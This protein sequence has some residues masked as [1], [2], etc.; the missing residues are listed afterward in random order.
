M[1]LFALDL[2]IEK[3]QRL[4]G[5]DTHAMAFAGSIRNVSNGKKYYI[6]I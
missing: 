5:C 1:A 3:R 6:D 2:A 4:T